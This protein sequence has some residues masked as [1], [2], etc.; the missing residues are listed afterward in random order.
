[1]R[2]NSK[3]R[4]YGKKYFDKKNYNKINQCDTIFTL[5]A[6]LDRNRE[7]DQGVMNKSAHAHSALIRTRQFCTYIVRKKCGHFNEVGK[8][9][10][11]IF[12]CFGCAT[13]RKAMDMM[14]LIQFDFKSNNLWCEFQKNRLRHSVP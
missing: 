13:Q 12:V 8:I 2:Y 14:K 10:I 3:K 5:L 6:L 4:E 11:V 7:N 1:M 9:L